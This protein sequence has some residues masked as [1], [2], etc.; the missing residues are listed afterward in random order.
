MGESEYG[1]LGCAGVGT[2]QANPTVEPEMRILLPGGVNQ[3]T[4]RLTSAIADSRD[5]LI[6]YIE[7][8]AEYL[9]AYDRLALDVFGF[10]CTGSSY[11]VGAAREAVITAAVEA[12]GGPPVITAAAAIR[13]ALSHIG[14]R[15]IAIV[16]PYP[17]WLAEAGER[18]WRDAGLEVVDSVR[19]ETSSGDTRSVYGVRGAQVT[20]AAA[21][22]AA[23][24]ADAILL[25]GTGMPTLR[26]IV[27]IERATG[28]P[29]LS[30]NLCLAWAV[31][32]EL[33]LPEAPEACGAAGTGET[34]L[35]GW[36]GRLP[37]A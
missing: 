19:I 13:A 23:E 21:R 25:S 28:R 2:P 16:A 22:L 31:L 37:P 34:I 14:A 1:A 35:R 30:S 32:H 36:P 27:A 8:L 33:G 12:D 29:V 10:A 9:A 11:L 20:D 7:R 18:Y 6:D 4:T 3:Q 17:Q 15:R 5:R 26:A 24:G